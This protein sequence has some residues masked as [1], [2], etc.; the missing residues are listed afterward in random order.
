MNVAERLL[1][2]LRGVDTVADVRDVTRAMVPSV[3]L[4]AD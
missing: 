2:V 3:A 1:A 4:A